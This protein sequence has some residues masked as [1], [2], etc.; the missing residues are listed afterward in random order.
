MANALNRQHALYILSIYLHTFVMCVIRL[1]ERVG[2]YSYQ[3]VAQNN[4][5]TKCQVAQLEDQRLQAL[6]RTL[7]RPSQKPCPVCDKQSNEP[8]HFKHYHL[9]HTF[10]SSEFIINSR[11]IFRYMQAFPTFCIL[12]T[13][14]PCSLVPRLVRGRGE[15][16]LIHTICAYSVFPEFGNSRKICSLH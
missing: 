12:V 6:Y 9:S 5:R 8:S 16:S 14:L 13:P 4:S 15:K 10:V 7:T 11:D 1:L 2:T 3:R